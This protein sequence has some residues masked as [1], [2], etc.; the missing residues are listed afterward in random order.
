[1][2]QIIFKM[3]IFAR[4]QEICNK[5]TNMQE[6]WDKLTTYSDY[7]EVLGEVSSLPWAICWSVLINS[8]RNRNKTA[9]K[10]KRQH[11][12]YSNTCNI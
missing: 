9:A 2:A 7:V 5:L 1:M 4:K 6:D 10:I 8:C 3:F 12:S 11:L